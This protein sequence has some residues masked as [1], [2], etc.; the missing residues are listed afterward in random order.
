MGKSAMDKIRDAGE[1]RKEASK[2]QKSD[3]TSARML[4]DVA[5]KKTRAA[6]KQLRSRPKRKKLTLK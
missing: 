2:L 6:I 3:P 5:S 1:L 4:R